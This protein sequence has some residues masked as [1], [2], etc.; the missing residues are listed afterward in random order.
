M[1]IFFLDIYKQKKNMENKLINEVYRINEL[2][3][4]DNIIVENVS[5]SVINSLRKLFTSLSDDVIEKFVVKTGVSAADTEL[6]NIIT[7]L[8]TGKNITEKSLNKLLSQINGVKL[9]KIFSKSEILM[10]DDFFKDISK[11][12]KILKSNPKKYDDV[13]IGINNTIDNVPY[14]KELPDNLKNSLKLELKGEMDIAKEAGEKAKATKKAAQKAAESA[15]DNFDT[16]TRELISVEPADFD[17]TVM[18][19]IDKLGIKL[20]LKGK[21][22]ELFRNELISVFKNEFPKRFP[23]DYA[24]Q[25]STISSKLSELSPSQQKEFL[26]KTKINFEKA[27][28]DVLNKGN[29][30]IATKQ[31]LKDLLRMGFNKPTSDGTIVSKIKWFFQWWF[32]TIKVSASISLLTIV[33]DLVQGELW[34]RLTSQ[35]GTELKKFLRRTLIPAWNIV[36]SGFD[37]LVSIGKGLIK[38]VQTNDDEKNQSLVDKAQSELFKRKVAKKHPSFKFMDNIIIEYGQPFLIIDGT[39]YPIYEDVNNAKYFI[40]VDGEGVYFDN[41]TN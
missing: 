7:K 5:V 26:T 14:L 29:F 38:A 13:I 8:K 32:Y 35:P 19:L 3:G 40:K 20:K 24:S 31:E 36:E 12:K 25:L 17:K 39:N 27:F 11:Y 18:S 28:G 30:S 41:L 1:V 33:S 10:G 34:D 2:M 4:I 37:A 9:A 22:L 15:P 21:N 23:T 16:L 6:D